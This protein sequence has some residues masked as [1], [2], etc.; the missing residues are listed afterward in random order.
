MRVLIWC[1]RSW[2]FVNWAGAYVL[3][4]FNSPFKTSTQCLY[5]IIIMLFAA[6]SAGAKTYSRCNFSIFFFNDFTERLD[7]CLNKCGCLVK[8]S[9]LMS[10][11]RKNSFFQSLRA[12]TP[13]PSFLTSVHNSFYSSAVNFVQLRHIETWDYFTIKNVMYVLCCVLLDSL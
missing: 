8:L 9:I 12:C 5:Q 6:L 7:G 13:T 4:E 10:I 11:L 1:T 2:S 3:V